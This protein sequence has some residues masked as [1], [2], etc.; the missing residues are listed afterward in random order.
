M[1]TYLTPRE[2]AQML[3]ISYEKALKFIKYSGIKYVKIG[4]HYRVSEFA[5]TT[6]LQKNTDI[7][8]I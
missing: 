1:T 5:L 4:N 2:I 7:S 8:C 6:F 3:Q